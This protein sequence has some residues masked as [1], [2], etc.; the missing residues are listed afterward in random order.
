MVTAALASARAAQHAQLVRR[1]HAAKG[2][3]QLDDA[4]YRAAIA[5]HA[6]GK[7]SSLECSVAELAALVEHFHACG[8]P[9]PG[10][11]RKPLAP[12]QKKL[13]ALWCA[14]ADQGRVRE[15]GMRGLLKW[16]EHQTDNHVQ[17]LEFL[18]RA[19]EETLIESLKKWGQRA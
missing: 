7:T 10:K 3:L 16:I 8:W 5:A 13:Y 18:T 15:R 4:T 11:A 12:R 14:L 17:K 2:F 1:V 6:G 9:R 19:Q